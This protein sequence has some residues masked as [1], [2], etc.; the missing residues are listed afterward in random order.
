MKRFLLLLSVFILGIGYA[1]AMQ[2]EYAAPA[3]TYPGFLPL[4]QTRFERVPEE[5]KAQLIEYTTMRE[6]LTFWAIEMQK[7]ANTD[8]QFSL[9]GI[10]LPQKFGDLGIDHLL[11]LESHLVIIPFNRHASVWDFQTGK[12]HMTLPERESS[13]A[14]NWPT[15]DGRYH[16]YSPDKKLIAFGGL[17]ALQIRFRDRKIKE[18]IPVDVVHSYRLNAL[19]FSP[20]STLLATAEYECRARIWDVATWKLIH[21][22]RG[23]IR[24]VKWVC[25]SPDG[26]LIA[27]ASD[28][29]TVRIWNVATGKVIQILTGHTTP[30]QQVVFSPKGNQLVTASSTA[31]SDVTVRIWQL[32]SDDILQKIHRLTF[33]AKLILNDLYLAYLKNNHFDLHAQPEIWH[34]LNTLDINLK[35]AINNLNLIIP[36]LSEINEPVPEEEFSQPPAKRPREEKEI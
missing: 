20:D 18:S 17:N 4:E 6:A 22:L 11:F 19:A 21:E 26:S 16:A 5:L 24:P 9:P 7:A 10:I 14:A 30:V 27:T 12:L 32:Y 36:P 35:K 34:F 31:S 3:L 15:S 25:F 2:P 29:C 8:P 13:N 33:E 28:D 1:Q 23:H